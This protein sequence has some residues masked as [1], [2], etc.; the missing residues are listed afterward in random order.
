MK[1]AASSPVLSLHPFS[2]GGEHTDTSVS[3]LVD[4]SPVA[5]IFS[6]RAT[7]S[8]AVATMLYPVDVQQ[9]NNVLWVLDSTV[10]GS[11]WLS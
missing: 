4:V 10:W 3:F 2:G 9:E 5:A 11:G 1:P 7:S 8:A 6:F